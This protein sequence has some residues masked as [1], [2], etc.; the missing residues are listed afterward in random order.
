[1]SLYHVT[2]TT[3]PDTSLLTEFSLIG[4][5]DIYETQQFGFY[6]KLLTFFWFGPRPDNY[7]MESKGQ[8]Q[9]CLCLSQRNNSC[10]FFSVTW[11][12]SKST[13]QQHIPP[14]TRP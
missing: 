11:T 10:L 1:M 14:P 12:A 9:S 2:L 8:V 13:E 3:L 4:S 7:N 5:T 6:I